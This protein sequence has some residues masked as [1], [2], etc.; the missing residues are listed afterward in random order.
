MI[1]FFQAGGWLMFPI[2]LSSVLALAIIFDRALALRKGKVLPRKAIKKAR[3]IAQSG[4]V[5]SQ[6]V[7]AIRDSSLMG[8]VL[9]VGLQGANL[10]RHVL[11]E[12]VEEAGRHVVHD[13]ERYMPALGTIAA[14]TP[15]M[16][17]LGT[18]LGMIQVFSVITEVGVGSPTDL[19]GG[20]SQ[21]LIT[22]AAGIFVAIISLIFHRYYKA[23]IDH[24]IIAMEKEAMHLLELMNQQNR[25]Q[26]PNANVTPTAP[27][28]TTPQGSAQSSQGQT[29]TMPRNKPTPEQIKAQIQ[30]KRAAKA[31][32]AARKSP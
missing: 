29:P 7:K 30:A 27:S 4:Q 17:L 31:A 19:A 6:E 18:V 14:I 5:P 8:R 20:I 26:A 16:G 9:A 13:M 21:A 3:Q 28:R 24:Y 23:K 12:N 2:V 11:K 22:T 25:R 1:E 10:P 32:A 15:L